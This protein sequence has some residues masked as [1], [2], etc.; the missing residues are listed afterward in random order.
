MY[1]FIIELVQRA[2]PWLS[3]GEFKVR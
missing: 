1:D 3:I 2:D